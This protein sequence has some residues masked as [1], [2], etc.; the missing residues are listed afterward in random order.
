MRGYTFSFRVRFLDPSKRLAQAAATEAIKRALCAWGGKQ[1]CGFTLD[2]R[3]N[4]PC[5]EGVIEGVDNGVVSENALEALK[6]R[7]YDQLARAK[8][9]ASALKCSY[10]MS[11][12]AAHAKPEEMV[13]SW[14]A[15]KGVRTG[16]VRWQTT[17]P[18]APV[19][20]AARAAVVPA[21]SEPASS[22]EAPSEEQG[23]SVLR[24]PLS[25]VLSCP[26]LTAVVAAVGSDLQDLQNQVEQV[27]SMKD[28]L[29]CISDVV[30]IV[31]ILHRFLEQMQSWAAKRG[32][33]T[34]EGFC[35]PPAASSSSP[36]S[37]MAGRNPPP[38]SSPPGPPIAAASAH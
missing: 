37:T 12:F 20:L 15:R 16:Y 8:R 18:R 28:A 6:K 32:L 38:P 21:R 2:A 14:I 11:I 29:M 3:E 36:T 10:N 30:Q 13:T 35:G 5:L 17:L 26:P 9:R 4:G 7:L 1:R 24:S 22:V 23:V 25:A 27:S 33:D 19:E 31:E 34:A